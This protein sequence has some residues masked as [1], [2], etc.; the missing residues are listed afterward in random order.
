MVVRLVTL[1]QGIIRF[2]WRR[3]G[4]LVGCFI[5]SNSGHC[6]FGHGQICSCYVYRSYSNS[7]R[8][9]LVKCSCV[10]TSYCWCHDCWHFSCNFLHELFYC[11]YGK[12][13][14]TS[15]I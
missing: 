8:Q 3:P 9:L 1:T 15:R 12:L 5:C 2:F 11:H 13:P 6:C 7:C 4:H 14:F 10:L